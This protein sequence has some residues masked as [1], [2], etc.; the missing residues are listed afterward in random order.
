[1]YVFDLPEGRSFGSSSFDT[2]SWLDE[3]S[4]EPRIEDRGELVAGRRGPPTAL[5][6]LMPGLSV[7]T[8]VR[9]IASIGG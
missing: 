9:Y 2:G 7:V 8:L 3:L 6:L 4:C 5:Y 1:M